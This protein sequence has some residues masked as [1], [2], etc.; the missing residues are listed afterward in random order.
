VIEI[1]GKEFIEKLA[2]QENSGAKK[3]A[4]DAWG[5][6]TLEKLSGGTL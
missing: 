2:G 1:A 4:D 3:F 6:Y 5:R